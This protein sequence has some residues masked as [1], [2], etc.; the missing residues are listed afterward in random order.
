MRVKFSK[1]SY[2]LFFTAF[3]LFMV[4]LFTFLRGAIA[5]CSA[6][7]LALTRE[8][9]LSDKKDGQGGQA[10]KFTTNPKIV[11][12]KKVV[13]KK[14]V[15][16][17]TSKPVTLKLPKTPSPVVLVTEDF[18]VWS[19]DK[20]PLSPKMRKYNGQ[21]WEDE[22]TK[23]IFST[24]GVRLFILGR[25]YDKNPVNAITSNTDKG[26]KGMVWKDDSIEVFL[27]KNSSSKFY[28]QYIVSVSGVGTVNYMKVSGANSQY[29][30]SKP[31]AKFQ[32]PRF[33]ASQHKNGFEVEMSISLSNI[34]I[35]YLKPGDSFLLQIVRNYRGQGGK[36]SV[37][38]QMFPVYIYADSRGGIANHDRRAFQPVTVKKM[39]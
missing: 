27:M 19:N 16:R 23:F 14:K 39:P 4:L 33:D 12:R 15:V 21:K 25:L 34:G 6:G 28:C 9:K 24:N 10:I 31:P 30:P 1:K 22:N 7:L 37:T 5:E 29:R 18:P 13:Q 32:Y 36:D 38:L 20:Y 3:F 17:K 26:N 11:G 2:G 8:I 35:S